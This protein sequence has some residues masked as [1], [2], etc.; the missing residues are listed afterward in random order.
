[1]SRG[2]RLV[3]VALL[4]ACVAAAQEKLEV[5]QPE[6]GTIRLGDTARVTVRVEGKSANPRTPELPSVAGLRMRL[7]LVHI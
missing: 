3:A 5:S 4:A 7:S 1:M 6:P 2:A